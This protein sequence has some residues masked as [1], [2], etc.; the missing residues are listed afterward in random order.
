MTTKMK[1]KSKAALGILLTLSTA[2]SWWLL[3]NIMMLIM[4]LF[5]SH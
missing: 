2:H 1:R 3:I 5:L 4:A